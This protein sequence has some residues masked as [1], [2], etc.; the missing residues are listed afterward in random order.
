MLNRSGFTCLSGVLALAACT[1]A[2]GQEEGS[3]AE[4]YRNYCIVCHGADARGTGPLATELPVA[5]ADLTQLAARNGGDFPSSAVMA[6]IYGYPG[7]YHSMPEFGPLL[8]GPKVAWVD[9]TGTSIAT[10]RPLLE[11]HN[12]LVSLQTP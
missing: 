9:E 12:Y 8:A 7:Q 10:P 6:K 2:P 11:L 5:P 1:V 3:G 4:I